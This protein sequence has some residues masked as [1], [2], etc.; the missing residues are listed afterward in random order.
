MVV[1]LKPEDDAEAV[2]GK[3]KAF[4]AERMMKGSEAK[5]KLTS[6]LDGF[7]FLGWRFYVQKNNGK[8]RSEPSEANYQAFRTKA[9][10]VILN[11]SLSFELRAQKLAPIVRGWRNYH[12]FTKLDGSRFSLWRLNHA[13]FKTFLKGKNTSRYEAERLVKKA[14]PMVGW[15]ENRFVGLTEKMLKKQNYACSKCGLKLWDEEKVHLH[16]VDGNHANWEAK[17]LVV[18]HQS[19]HQETHYAA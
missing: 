12:R 2:L 17:N 16:H 10:A 6:T 19:C 8:F 1:F 3:I 7:D 4:L 11:P 13:A 15:S 14:F 9:K 5:T 18:M